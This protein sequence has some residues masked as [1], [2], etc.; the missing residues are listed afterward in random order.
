VCFSLLISLT[1][2]PIENDE[3]SHKI[4]NAIVVSFG[5][6]GCNDKQINTNNKFIAINEVS[7]K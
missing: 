7:N 1:I 2:N 4:K 6:K 5:V 3:Q